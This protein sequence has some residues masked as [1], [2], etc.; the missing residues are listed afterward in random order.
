MNALAL[1]NCWKWFFFA[2]SVVNVLLDATKLASDYDQKQQQ[3]Q[4]Y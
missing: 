3:Q 2:H 1:E 4:S